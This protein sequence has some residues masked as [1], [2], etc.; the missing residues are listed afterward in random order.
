MTGR[1]II[2]YLAILAFPG[3]HALKAAKPADR[4]GKKSS[5]KTAFGLG[6][7]GPT[8]YMNWDDVVC[9]PTAGVALKRWE[10]THRSVEDCCQASFEPKSLIVRCTEA[11]IESSQRKL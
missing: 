8:Y 6:G 9:L 3:A 2:I 4:P 7:S 10:E 1:F 5:A 11:S